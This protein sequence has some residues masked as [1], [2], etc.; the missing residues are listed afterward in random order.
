M[1]LGKGLVP[2]RVY[3][4]YKRCTLIGIGAMMNMLVGANA[5]ADA[6]T[7]ADADADANDWVT[8]L[9]LLDFVRRAKNR[10]TNIFKI[11]HSY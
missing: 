3:A 4:K 2:R 9:A 1:R 10:S 8:T 6:D 5:D 7:D 11:S